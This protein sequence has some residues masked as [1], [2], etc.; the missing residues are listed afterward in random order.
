M[1][2]KFHCVDKKTELRL[3]GI[4]PIKGAGLYTEDFKRYAATHV[5][6]KLCRKCLDKL[7][8]PS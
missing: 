4:D 7:E 1:A 5:R 3:C 6:L 2:T 8:K